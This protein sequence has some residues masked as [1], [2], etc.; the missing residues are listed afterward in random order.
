MRMPLSF[1][2]LAW[3]ERE[4]A[5][6]AATAWLERRAGA[7]RPGGV[8]E[9]L[10]NANDEEGGG[11]R[12]RRSG[13]APAGGVAERAAAAVTAVDAAIVDEA[14]DEVSSS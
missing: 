13:L 11:V 2:V 1:L 12:Q 4:R 14:P 7:P 8:V 3:L 9:V 6:P 5:E 10:W